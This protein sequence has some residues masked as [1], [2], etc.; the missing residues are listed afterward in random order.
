MITASSKTFVNLG[1]TIRIEVPTSLGFLILY[2]LHIDLSYLYLGAVFQREPKYKTFILDCISYMVERSVLSCSCKYESYMMSLNV[3]INIIL[4]LG[5]WYLLGSYDQRGIYSFVWLSS[6]HPEPSS[7]L[8]LGRSFV[9]KY[10]MYQVLL[11]KEALIY[12]IKFQINYW[13]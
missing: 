4:K 11:I 1:L 6:S 3:L 13:K 2:H 9:E 12:Y 5:T 8:F 10:C 7:H